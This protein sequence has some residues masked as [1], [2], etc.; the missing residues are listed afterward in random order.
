MKLA[1]RIPVEPLDDE[2]MT[3]I[4]RRIVAGAA[5]AAVMP[6]RASRLSVALAFAAVAVVAVMGA[7]MVGWKLRGGDAPSATT[8]EVTPIQVRTD[9]QRSTLDI[10][11]AR[12]QSGPETAFEIT[13]PD[14]GVL[15]TMTR[16]KVTLDVGKRGDRPALVVKA[17][18]TDVV[19]VGTQFSVDFGDG[20]GDVDV[21]VTEGIVRVVRHKQETRVAAGQ[22][23][24][25]KR[26]L[27]ALSDLGPSA[28]GAAGAAGVAD[29]DDG[30]K[31]TDAAGRTTGDGFEIDMGDAPDVLRERVATI[32][33][34]R[35]RQ[36]G[37][38]T[39]LGRGPTPGGGGGGES[40]G[41]PRPLD[42]PR[43]P[44]FDLK[45]LIRSQPV[46]PALDVGEPDALKA[47]AEYR[48]IMMREKGANEA[49]AFYSM[50]VI[51]ALKLG[52]TGD[53]LV[54]LSAFKRRA[55]TNEYYIPALW[56]EVRIK[57]LRNIDD[58][59]RQ[60]AEVYKRR[61]S[62]G[63]TFHVAEKITLSK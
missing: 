55:P 27:L 34:V 61:A 30:A 13:R 9:E 43:D 2:R 51:Q 31:I 41:R 21:R 56:L 10:G 62:E 37:V 32:P 46:L 24:T 42:D 63:P 39:T 8:A 11:D 54:T 60:A 7:G 49:H 1:G 3:N 28:A 38:G 33:D 12:L 17:G 4:E 14:G 35:V 52:R 22:A 23:W 15:V 50:A 26:G 5:D 18:D 58:D 19:V 59:C 53:A 44:K 47:M 16:G 20:T 36:Q 45:S 40:S 25:S 29:V 48:Q 57:C 6:A